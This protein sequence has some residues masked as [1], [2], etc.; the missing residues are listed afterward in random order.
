M[1]A[2]VDPLITDGAIVLAHDAVGPGALR[3]DCAETVAL[4]GPLVALA[5]ERGLEPAPLLR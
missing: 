5:R 4:I 3:A 2:L 1:L